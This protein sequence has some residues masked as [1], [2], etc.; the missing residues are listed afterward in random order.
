MSGGPDS[1]TPDSIPTAA[2]AGPLTAYRSPLTFTTILPRDTTLHSLDLAIVVVY[3][4][5]T[6]GIGAWAARSQKSSGDY[7]LG[8]RD[9][10]A[11][12]VLLS[13][14][15]TETSALTVVSIPGLGARTD[16]TFLQ[17][18]MGYIVGRIAVAAWLLPGYFAHTQE[19]AYARLESRF[20]P[21]TR[22]LAAAVFIVTRF[23]GDAVRVFAGAIPMALLTGWNIPLTIM[24]L[25][26]VT[27]VYTWHGGLKAVV[28][29]DVVQLVVYVTGGVTALVIAVQLAGGWSAAWD[30]A[31]A[32]GKL[33][34]IRPE[35]S[36][37]A[38]YTL[39]AGLLGGALLSA[40]SH[41]T[42]HLIVQRLLATRSLK[43]GRIALVGSG[44]AVF[45]QFTLFLAVGVAIWTAGAAPE[46]VISDEIFP[47]F[48]IQ[49]FPVGL[50]GLLVAGILAASMCS[51]SSAISALASSTTY[52][53]YATWTGK[54]DQ[55]HLFKIGRGFTIFWGLALIGGSLAFHF[56]SRSGTPI[57]VLALSIASV[58]YGGLLGAYILAGRWPRATGRD[59]I[60]AIATTTAV[61]LVVVF[62]KVLAE[63]LSL[64]WLAPVGR[65]AW[66]WYVPLGTALALLSGIILSYFPRTPTPSR[67]A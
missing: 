28:W 46:G 6:L 65:L 25:G 41:G 58:T 44:F 62:A 11:F 37:T 35:L 29:T 36:F 23:L 50:T 8:A 26:L 10:P 19:T 9:L 49:H 5:L 27:V 43:D 20:G 17:V 54:S 14:V 16:L 38:P 63:S 40:A 67:T 31:S 59:V 55:D 47:R 21:H 24:V 34:L 45:V 52:D 13:I 4:A 18:V 64:D 61:M 53:L 56:F 33:R 57:V 32:A 15:A 12:A 3:V 7:F 66:P 22:R 30:A 48:V 42:D 1:G 39:L 2:H 60:G 51:H